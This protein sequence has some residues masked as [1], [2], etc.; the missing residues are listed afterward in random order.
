MMKKKTCK[1]VDKQ[2]ID[3]QLI[4]DTVLETKQ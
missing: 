3:E 4:L 1:N 2:D